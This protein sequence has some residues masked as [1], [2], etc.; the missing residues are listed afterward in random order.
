MPIV[1]IFTF[2]IILIIKSNIMKH[3]SYT[4]PL[5]LIKIA[6]IKDDRKASK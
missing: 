4:R 5:C 6:I 3:F 2:R 1:I